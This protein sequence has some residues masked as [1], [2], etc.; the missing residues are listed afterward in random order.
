MP[1]ESFIKKL[2]DRRVL[3]IVPFIIQKVTLMSILKVKLV[4]TIHCMINSQILTD[5]QI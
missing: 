5:M 1:Q 2:L 3:L 4:I